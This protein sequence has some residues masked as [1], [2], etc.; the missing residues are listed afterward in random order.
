MTDKVDL[1]R[2]LDSFRAR[3]GEFRVLD[4]GPVVTE[5]E[6]RTLSEGRCAQTLHVGSFDDEADVLARLHHE[7]A[8]RHGL[9][10]TGRHHEVYLSDVRRTAPEGRRTILRSRCARRGG[11]GWESRHPHELT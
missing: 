4:I 3:A 5:V 8:P 7:L 11:E 2:T 6:A 9:R 10:L 1:K